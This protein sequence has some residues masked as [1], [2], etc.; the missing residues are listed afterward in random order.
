MSGCLS[1]ASPEGGPTMIIDCAH[2]QDGHRTDESPVPLEEAAA[3][4]AQGGFVWLG[5]FEPG[6]EEM[7]R[8][9]ELFGLHW[10]A[11]EDAR[12]YHQR[13]KIE[14][15]D[16]GVRLVVLRTARYDND[17]E[18]IDFGQVSVFISPTFVITVRQ[19]VASRLSEA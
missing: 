19:G 1:G 5:L 8:V 14:T 15:Y 18:R 9:R 6:E 13:P 7:A 2:Y 16:D 10:L 3:R 4:A 17:E 11:V 12:N